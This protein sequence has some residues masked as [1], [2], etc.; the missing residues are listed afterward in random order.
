M[1]IYSFFNKMLQIGETIISLD[2]LEKK[3]CCD[4]SKCKGACCIQ[5]DSGAPLTKEEASILN[6]IFP[7]IKS[8]L[9]KES[10]EVIE[11]N[12]CFTIDSDRDLVTP[13][14]NNEECVYVIFEDNI[15]KCAIEKAFQEGVITFHKPVSCHLYPIRI[16][17][18][19]TFDAL[20]YHRWE[21]C[22]EAIKYGIKQNLP[23]YVFLQKPLIRKYGADF[24]EQLQIAAREITNR[25]TQ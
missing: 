2:I 1:V 14:I 22:K 5:G 15:A 20:N 6:G 3:F 7:S 9:R 12:G 17:S 16:T 8:Y 10:I 25:K 4:L 21:I 19:S 11:K 18:Y 23:L 13:L 24:Y